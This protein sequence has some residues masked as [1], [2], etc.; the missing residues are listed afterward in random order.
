MMWAI[1][2]LG[3]SI[4]GYGMILAV[5][6]EKQT[7]KEKEAMDKVCSRCC[8]YETADTIEGEKE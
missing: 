3:V 1:I 8:L 4:L 6:E 7:Q 2:V 5:I